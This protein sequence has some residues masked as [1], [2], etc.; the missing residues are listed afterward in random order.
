MRG[1]FWFR[2]D[3]RI[4]DNL[5]LFQ[6]SQNCRDGL[7]A[8]FY[9]PMQTWQSQR[10][11]GC[12]VSLILKQL[13]SIKPHLEKLNIPLLVFNVNTFTDS[14]NH[15]VA[16]MQEHQV[17]AVYFNRQYEWDERQRDTLLES[18]IHAQ[19]KKIMAFDDT[20]MS[21]PG[22][23]LTTKLQ[24]YTL[25]T[26]FKKAFM[27]WHAQHG[28]MHPVKPPEKQIE[29][30]VQSSAIPKSVAGF[31][32]HINDDLWPAGEAHALNRLNVFINNH[33]CNYAYEREFPILD[34]TSQLSPYI[35]IGALSPRQCLHKALSASHL[36]SKKSIDA[37]VT[38]LIWREFYQHIV[39][40]FPHI[41]KGES[42]HAKYDAIEWV[43]NLT[44]QKAWID[45]QTGFP[46]V[47]AAMRQLRETGWMHNRLRMLV[48]MFF[49]KLLYQDWR[50]G[51]AF[52][53][54]HLID[55][56]F[57]ANNGGWQ[58]CAS[59]G[60]D[61]APYFR[62]FNPV[63][64]SENFDPEGLFIKQYC[65]ELKTLSE[66]E[67]HDPWKLAPHK[68]SKLGYPKPIIEYKT[69]R[70]QTLA[71]FKNLRNLQVV[72]SGGAS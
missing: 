24:A 68:V 36:T 43:E 7:A 18:L 1:I 57:A 37:W 39:Y 42:F 41:C 61:A 51:E 6:A 46:L 19:D 66:Y 40:H 35:N 60:T 63:R 59:T 45:G 34:G 5:A 13:E 11:A 31:K 22:K 21:P 33:L 2:T 71:A 15:L 47:D 27:S 67:I 50:V 53:M 10:I 44:W 17:D 49:N 4:D 38:E 25:F 32:S 62:I 16:F 29:M 72:W 52:F 23:I 64:Q 28:R 12:K 56:S 20:V 9:I 14:V 54:E 65:P 58:W 30:F 3:L 26:P 48:A 55:G 8:V 69:M 70:A